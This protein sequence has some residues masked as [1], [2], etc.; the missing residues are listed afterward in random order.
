MYMLFKR[1]YTNYSYEYRYIKV[2]KIQRAIIQRTLKYFQNEKIN[3][4]EY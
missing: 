3:I 1:Y 4:P 2:N